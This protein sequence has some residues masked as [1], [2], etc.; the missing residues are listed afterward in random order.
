MICSDIYMQEENIVKA[1]NTMSFLSPPIVRSAGAILDRSLFSKTFPVAA[2]RIKNLKK[3]SEYKAQLQS[4][5][6]LLRLERITDVQPDPDPSLANKGGKC[7]LLSPNIKPGD[8]STWS[9]NLR[10]AVTK[11]EIQVVPYDLNLGYNYWS[12][13]KYVGIVKCRAGYLLTLYR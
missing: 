11:E 1:F 3:I 9:H 8:S 5:Q 4:T 6:E 12:Y 13:R 7:M 2:A 10:E